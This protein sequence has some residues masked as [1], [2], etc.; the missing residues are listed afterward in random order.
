MPDAK[1]DHPETIVI[2]DRPVPEGLR[3]AAQRDRDN[4]AAAVAAL[5]ESSAAY[6][7]MILG[8]QQL[9][10]EWIGLIDAGKIDS[11]RSALHR[12]V[13]MIDDNYDFSILAPKTDETK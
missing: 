3:R 10:V 5:E 12:A 11:A 2:P 4:F 9:M 1:K 13:L 6:L 7:E 8:L